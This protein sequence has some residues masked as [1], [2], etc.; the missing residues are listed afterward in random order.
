[1]AWGTVELFRNSVGKHLDSHL[2]HGILCVQ[3]ILLNCPIFQKNPEAVITPWKGRENS[4]TFTLHIILHFKSSL[5]CEPV[6]STGF[7]DR[8]ASC[9]APIHPPVLG[10]WP[11]VC[12]SQGH[13]SHHRLGMGVKTLQCNNSLTHQPTGG[14]WWACHQWHLQK[15][16]Q[17][18]HLR[19]SRNF[20]THK[21][22]MGKQLVYSPWLPQYHCLGWGKNTWT[23]FL[24]GT[25]TMDIIAACRNDLQKQWV[26]QPKWA[27][28]S[29]WRSSS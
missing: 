21:H 27:S 26:A 17:T 19:T 11:V 24:L 16:C 7:L 28:W 12:P 22:T 29:C 23:H 14:K 2:V 10:A 13:L 18:L 1:M 4:W 9:P 3:K 8:S 25:H 6:L 5:G 20:S 15:K